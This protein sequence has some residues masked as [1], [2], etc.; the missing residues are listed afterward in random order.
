MRYT[1]RIV[2]AFSIVISLLSSCAAM[3][4]MQNTKTRY[5]NDTE[6]KY[7]ILR[8]EGKYNYIT[9]L[10]E[11]VALITIR[12]KTDPEGNVTYDIARPYYKKA[13]V[14]DYNTQMELLKLNFP[15]LYSLYRDGRII[16]YDMYQFVDQK[17]G[18]VRVN[19]SYRYR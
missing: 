13:Y 12:E 14:R 3:K 10:K 16:I 2:V 18:T 17:T 4:E 19:V 5:I 15:E 9:Y 1:L 11:G 8:R 6:E 7:D